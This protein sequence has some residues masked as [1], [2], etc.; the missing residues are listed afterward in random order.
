MHKS[1][2]VSRSKSG[3]S[4]PL[5]SRKGKERARK[6]DDIPAINEVDVQGELI[7]KNE[8]EGIAAKGL[9]ELTRRS[10]VGEEGVRRNEAGSSRATS[11][12]GESIVL[13]GGKV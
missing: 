2:D 1:N 10:I 13:Q 9:R 7:L 3:R 4:T 5:S 12:K 11:I 8:G 6:E